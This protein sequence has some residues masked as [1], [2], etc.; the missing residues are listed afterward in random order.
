MP[1]AGHAEK[2]G[3]FTNTQRLLQWREKAVDPPGDSAQRELV[4]VIIWHAA[5]RRKRSKD[6]R[7]RNAGLRRFDLGLS[8]RRNASGADCRR[9]SAG[10]QRLHRGGSETGCRIHC[11]QGGWLD[12]VRLLDL[13]RRFSQ[14]RRK[15]REPA[16]ARRIFMAHGWG[17]AWP[18]DRR[19][20]YNRASARPDGQPWS[21]RKKLVWWDDAEQEV[22]RQ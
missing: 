5:S 12:G 19:I 22:D 7:P 18:S 8:R 17:F 16:R 6:P 11:A 20:I 3:T 9:S 1:A 14:A 15:S 2:D 4:H 10:N 13:F 21:E